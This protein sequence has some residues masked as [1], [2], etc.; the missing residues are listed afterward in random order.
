MEEGS[1]GKPQPDRYSNGS[2]YNKRAKSDRPPQYEKI[3]YDSV[4]QAADSRYEKK[5]LVN[6]TVDKIYDRAQYEVD[7]FPTDKLAADGFP[8]DKFSSEKQ[9][10]Y[11]KVTRGSLTKNLPDASYKDHL[12]EKFDK[13]ERLDKSHGVKKGS[14]GDGKQ[15]GSG[16]L[17]KVASTKDNKPSPGELAFQHGVCRCSAM[18][19][20]PHIHRSI[21]DKVS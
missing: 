9:S 5:H 17:S 20:R 6:D 10:R 18:G 16:R 3:Q 11:D 13:Y 19:G 1:T 15:G 8:S 2:S 4:N 7:K 21:D 12:K 14:G